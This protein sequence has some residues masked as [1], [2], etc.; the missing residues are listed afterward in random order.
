MMYPFLTLDD[1][2][3]ITH[4]EM[5]PDHRVKVY[6]EKPDETDGFHHMVCYLPSYDVA[7]VAGFTKDEVHHYLDIIRSTAHL[8]I[9]FSQEGGFEHAANF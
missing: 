7:D 2:A 1:E 8:M 5:L 6:V 9:E 4:S 3:E